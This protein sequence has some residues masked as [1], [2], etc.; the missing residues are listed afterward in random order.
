MTDRALSKVYKKI[1]IDLNEAF[2][3][4]DLGLNLEKYFSKWLN[5]FPCQQNLSTCWKKVLKHESRLKKG[6]LFWNAY[7][8]THQEKVLD[9]FK[10]GQTF[11]YSPF[12]FHF[13]LM[14]M[15]DLSSP[16]L[17]WVITEKPK[18]SFPVC[19]IPYSATG[20][21]FQVCLRYPLLLLLQLSGICSICT[22]RDDSSSFHRGWDLEP[23]SSERWLASRRWLW[24][25]DWV[26]GVLCLRWT[27]RLAF[28]KA[29]AATCACKKHQGRQWDRS[30]PLNVTWNMVL[31]M[32]WSLQSGT[33]FSACFFAF[34]T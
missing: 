12:P 26:L 7:L 3:D 27:L 4:A 25:Q 32:I 5:K 8:P 18:S 19:L 30:P 14:V 13:A 1:H 29:L 9:H 34:P 15:T 24:D 16:F 28:G 6:N 22:E 2:I 17:L 31:K 11:Q 23:L 10:G 33:V 21:V 20:S